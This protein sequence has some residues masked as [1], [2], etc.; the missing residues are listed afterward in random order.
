MA[1]LE[2]LCLHF[3]AIT[4]RSSDS[5]GHEPTQGVVHACLHIIFA[6]CNLLVKQSLDWLIILVVHTYTYMHI[7]LYN[8]V[9]G[10]LTNLKLMKS[11]LGKSKRLKNS[12]QSS[13]S[14]GLKETSM[15]E[16]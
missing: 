16:S 6:N 12:R 11:S 2:R 5:K 14:Y 13:A 1:V 7:P 4:C 3:S 8:I 9:A 10:R 15:R